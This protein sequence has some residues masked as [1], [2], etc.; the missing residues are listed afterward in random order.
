MIDWGKRAYQI[1]HERRF[2]ATPD[3]WAARRAAVRSVDRR[4]TRD[5][6]KAG[7]PPAGWDTSDY[8]NLNLEAREHYLNALN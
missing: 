6:I 5:F 1:E 7:R 2:W 4:L 3:P 8:D